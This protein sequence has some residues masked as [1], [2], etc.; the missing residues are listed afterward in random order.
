MFAQGA[1]VADVTA[2]N[3]GAFQIVVASEGAKGVANRGAILNVFT[4]KHFIDLFEVSPTSTSELGFNVTACV[5]AVSHTNIGPNSAREPRHSN[6][7]DRARVSWKG[8]C[9]LFFG[10]WTP[11]NPS[12][13][14]SKHSLI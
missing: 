4:S 11:V 2:S 12:P 9:L 13:Q 1:E 8:V 10:S 3:L 7:R 5:P 6:E 14:K